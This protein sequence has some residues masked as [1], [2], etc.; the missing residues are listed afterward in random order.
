MSLGESK[1][2]QVAMVIY[3]KPERRE[4]Y[5]ALHANPDPKVMQALKDANHR[6][7]RLYILGE[8]LLATYT[9]TG[10]NLEDDRAQLRARPELQA[11]MQLTAE[12]QSR[13]DVRQEGQWW[14]VMEPV[15]HNE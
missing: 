10:V 3:V 8:L 9:Y 5:L 14:S 6:D 11:W 1:C 12:M 4:E 15:L 7:Y 2:S 13:F